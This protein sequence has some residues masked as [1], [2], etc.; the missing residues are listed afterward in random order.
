MIILAGSSVPK[1]AQQIC[2]DTSSQWGLVQIG[3]FP[4]G[5][6]RIYIE[7]ELVGET[8]V[9]VQSFTKPVDEHVVEL[10]LLADAAAQ[11][12]AKRIIAVVPWLGYSP[13]DKLFRPGEPV[14]L[15]VV[16]KMIQASGVTD[17]VTMDLHSGQ[18][19]NFFS[20]QTQELSAL[21]L[22]TKYLR[23]RDLSDYVVISI[24][25]GSRRRSMHLSDELGLELCTFNKKRDLVTGQV[26]L[27]HVSGEVSGRRAVSFDD[28]IS[29]G[30]TQI[31][32]C[33]QLKSM[34]LLEYTACVTHAVFAGS[35]TSQ[36]LH[37][38]SI[39][40]IITTDTYPVPSHSDFLKLKVITSSNLFSQHLVQNYQ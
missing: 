33:S 13:Q 29:T 23:Q 1:L 37:D 27:V 17:I 2:Q 4:N 15:H 9:I 25:E 7:T 26:E 38:S 39:D 10:C 28:F 32:A 24:D 11:A 19:F 6:K 16:A 14:S 22:F 20:I 21:P 31:G 8:V 3:K 34:G 5:E 12:G 30:S 40:Q 35:D 18:A 36:K